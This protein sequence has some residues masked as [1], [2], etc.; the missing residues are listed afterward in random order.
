ML[1]CETCQE[2]INMRQFIEHTVRKERNMYAAIALLQHNIK[3]LEKEK[4]KRD[5]D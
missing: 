2:N 5:A 3:V 1:S 4:G